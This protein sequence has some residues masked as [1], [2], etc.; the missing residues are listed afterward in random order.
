MI[1]IAHF[2]LTNTVIVFS[3]DDHKAPRF[4]F[5]NYLLLISDKLETYILH[6]CSALLNTPLTEYGTGLVSSTFGNHRHNT[7]S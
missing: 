7:P 5:P 1:K 4:Y 6:V 3:T 2:I